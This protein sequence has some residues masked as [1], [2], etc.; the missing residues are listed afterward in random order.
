MSQI[1]H[2]S[3]FDIIP[4]I[5]YLYVNQDKYLLDCENV[6]HLFIHQ[7]NNGNYV[8]DFRFIT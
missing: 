2:L 1:I 5:I 7:P 4:G 8:L 3:I 6:R